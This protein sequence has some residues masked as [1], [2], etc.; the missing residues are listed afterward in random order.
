MPLTGADVCLDAPH[1]CGV[2]HVGSDCAMTSFHGRVVGTDC[3]SGMSLSP[4]P[5]Q[6]SGVTGWPAL[7]RGQGNPL[8]HKG[9]VGLG[10]ALPPLS[11]RSLYVSSKSV[12]SCSER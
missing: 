12:S 5:G 9:R 6:H 8:W 11:P 3:T 1:A 2:T 7:P 4:V 10:Q